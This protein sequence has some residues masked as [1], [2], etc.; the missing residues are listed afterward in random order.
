[1]PTISTCRAEQ[2][3]P[4]ISKLGMVT[5]VPTAPQPLPSGA[6]TG[7]GAG[8]AHSGVQGHP[9]GY[10]QG[11]GGSYAPGGSSME[12]GSLVTGLDSGPGWV[13]A[14]SAGHAMQACMD[15]RQ[16]ASTALGNSAGFPQQS[17]GWPSGAGHGSGYLSQPGLGGVLCQG[18]SVGGLGL[19]QG[20]PLPGHEP[21]VGGL[22]DWIV[23]EYAGTG[24]TRR[25]TQADIQVRAT[26]S[27]YASRS[28]GW[29]PCV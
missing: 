18:G 7:P 4:A 15:S 14:R 12:M 29:L 23:E 27:A 11:S 5:E 9:P 1:M 10:W 6:S 22:V 26:Q 20:S 16:P 19:A 24:L 21:S 28:L 13:G 2:W 25:L 17:L 8:L 3:R